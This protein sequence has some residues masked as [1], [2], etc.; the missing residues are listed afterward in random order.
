MVFLPVK[1]EGCETCA[2][3]RC[4]QVTMPHIL[5]EEVVWKLVSI[6]PGLVD[7]DRQTST[8]LP[9]RRLRH[10]SQTSAAC[11]HVLVSSP[12]FAV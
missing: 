1:Q 2:S 5:G 8:Q 7:A 11:S 10:A 6:Q 12:A 9:L 4:S 3:H